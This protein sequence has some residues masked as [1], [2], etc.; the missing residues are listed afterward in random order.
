MYTHKLIVRKPSNINKASNVI[1]VEYLRK[2][3]GCNVNIRIDSK[4]SPARVH[5]HLRENDYEV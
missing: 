5:N 1:T 2:Q 4:W 3:K